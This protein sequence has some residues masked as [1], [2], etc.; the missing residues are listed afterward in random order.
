LKC[1]LVLKRDQKTYKWYGRFMNGSRDYGDIDPKDF[2]KGAHALQLANHTSGDYEIGLHPAKDGDGF[3]VVFDA[4]GPGQRLTAAV[5]AGA[6]KLR[7]EYAAACAS[8]KAK[9]TLGRKGFVLT[10]EDLAGGRIRL[11]LRKR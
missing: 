1:G 9:V 4:W 2:G 10:R 5:E 7:R 3:Q 11:K 8:R 6:N